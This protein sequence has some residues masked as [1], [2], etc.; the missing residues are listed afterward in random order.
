MTGYIILADGF[1]LIE[2]LTPL[3]VLRRGGI[4]IKTVSINNMNKV[5]SSNGVHM[6]TDLVL[7]EEDLYKSEFIIL[8]G[9]YPGY[10]NLYKNLEVKKLAEFYLNNNKL[11]GAICGAPYTLS[12]WGLL[13]DRVVTC[14]SSV[15]E[16]LDVLRYSKDNIVVFGNLITSPGAGHSLTF[17]LT[18][19]EQLLDKVTTDK[20]KLGMEL[21]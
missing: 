15:S 6:L 19:A 3:D 1:E 11:V 9:G 14:H 16:N 18:I 10:E 21:K 8:P 4:D 20:I 17:S 2:A 13:K 12:R 7:G 5:T